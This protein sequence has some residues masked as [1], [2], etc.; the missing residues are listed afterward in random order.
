M[1]NRFCSDVEED[2]GK[3]GNTKIKPVFLN[4]KTNMLA[5]GCCNGW[6]FF[7]YKNGL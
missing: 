4:T 6:F 2:I 7:Y 3:T 1:K 5:N